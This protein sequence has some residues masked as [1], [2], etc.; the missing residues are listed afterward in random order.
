MKLINEKDDATCGRAKKVIRL[1]K[2]LKKDALTTS[3]QLKRLR[4]SCDGLAFSQP[5]ADPSC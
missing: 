2:N 1:F 4:S 3:H 5:Q